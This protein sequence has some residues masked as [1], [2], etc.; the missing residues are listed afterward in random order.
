MSEHAADNDVMSGPLALH[1]PRIGL[2]QTAAFVEFDIPCVIER[3]KSSRTALVWQA[4]IG[5]KRIGD[6]TPL[7]R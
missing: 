1:E 5:A 4:F 3:R 7:S 6:L 2:G